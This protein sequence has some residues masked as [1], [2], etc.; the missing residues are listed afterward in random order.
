MR[1]PALRFAFFV[2]GYQEGL[3]ALDG[4]L[5]L[6]RRVLLLSGQPANA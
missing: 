4:D 6:F 5:R 3:P 2:I 1:S